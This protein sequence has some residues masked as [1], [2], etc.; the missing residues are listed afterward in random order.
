MSRPEDSTKGPLRPSPRRTRY[1]L[2]LPLASLSG[3]FGSL[4]LVALLGCAT[5]SPFNQNFVEVLTPNFRVTSSLGEK[6]TRV[7]ARDLEAFHSGVLSALGLNPSA[8]RNH[9]TQVIAF[10]GRGFSRPFAE[11]GAS[12]SLIPTLD[13][14]VLMIRAEGDIRE[15]VDDELRHRYAHRILR[16]LSRADAPLWYE[17]GRAQVGGTVQQK[18]DVVI[19]GRSNEAFRR[20]L[21]DWRRDNLVEGLSR[22]SLAEATSAERERFD[23]ESWATVHTLLFDSAKRGKGAAAL[24]SVRVAFESSSPRRLE[25]ATAALGSESELTARIYTHLEEDRYRV[26][27][28]VVSGFTP[29]DL[30][31]E[32]LAPAIARDRLAQLALDLER[33]ALAAEYFER[34]LRDRPDYAPALAG[35]VLADALLGRTQGL[36]ERV[37]ALEKSAEAEIETLS[38]LALALLAAAVDA[39]E[40]NL[41]SAR[42][43]STRAIFERI[44]GLD[45]GNIIASVGIGSSLLVEGEDFEAAR[46]W[47]EAA[48]RESRGAL[49]LDL[50]MARG[51]I[52]SGRP[53]SAKA[54][55]VRA[56]SRSH[57]RR[58][59][60]KARELLERVESP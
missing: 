52:Q 8:Q 5:G 43:R 19:I 7:L 28:L 33:P 4:A 25:T 32:P 50:L 51:A 16:D 23:A 11:R 45:P 1:F 40:V 15:R 22:R 34:A 59:R 37:A 44:L 27:R 47:F 10:D 54:H 46:K 9:P 12:A 3:V 38:R 14:P 53:N 56:L 42:L 26:D 20:M 39:E 49:G 18:E 2:R 60:K 24:N 13:G 57:S 6:P 30:V 41:R 58:I 55:L 17:E 36:E 35:Q 21:L 31:V 29:E 48:Q